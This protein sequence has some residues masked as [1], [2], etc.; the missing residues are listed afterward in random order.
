[1]K[2]GKGGG[3]LCQ[4]FVVS[5]F[6]T[7]KYRIEEKSKMKVQPPAKGREKEKKGDAKAKKTQKE[8]EIK[9][10]AERERLKRN[11]HLQNDTTKQVSC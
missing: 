11:C 6:H 9:K 10:K 2:D 1:L 4:R 5:R 3:I 7:S 8:K